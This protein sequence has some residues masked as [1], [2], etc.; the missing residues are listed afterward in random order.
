MDRLLARYEPARRHARAKPVDRALRGGRHFRLA[1]HAEIVVGGPADQFPAA[2]LRAVGRQPLVEGEV[3]VFQARVADHRKVLLQRTDFRKLRDVPDV[4]ADLDIHPDGLLGAFLRRRRHVVDDRLGDL[5]AGLDLRQHLLR[6][7]GTVG[8]LEAGNDLHPLQR[9]E[10]E[11]DDVG[12]EREFAG[13]LLGDAT[14]MTE[15][16]LHDV[17]WEFAIRAVGPRRFTHRPLPRQSRQA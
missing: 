16:R 13:P 10:A 9:V 15:D 1:R 17:L 14:D 11:L 8:L 3:G 4:T 12:V 7:P 6:E 2:D 5:P